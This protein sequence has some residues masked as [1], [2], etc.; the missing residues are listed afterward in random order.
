MAVR[1]L[2]LVFVYLLFRWFRRWRLKSRGLFAPLDEFQSL[3][4]LFPMFPYRFLNRRQ[5]LLRR[6]IKLRPSP[7][8]PIRHL[9]KFLLQFGL[10]IC[11][12]SWVL[13]Y[14]YLG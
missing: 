13:F 10:V 8:E 12:R 14:Q 6:G 1:L 7:M 4:F 2:A 9:L 11:H 3:L 5:V